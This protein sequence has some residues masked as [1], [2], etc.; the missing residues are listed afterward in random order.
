[1]NEETLSG[2]PNP[3]PEISLEQFEQQLEV[4]EKGRALA[5]FVNDVNW[6][7]VLQVLQDYRD[8]A[9]DALIALPPGDPQVPLAHAAASATH[10]VFRNFQ[11]DISRAVDFA[12]NPPAEFKQ[13]MLGVRDS[14]DVA[15]I[16][17]SRS[18]ER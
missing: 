9:R 7:T 1:M 15:K 3:D 17:E 10:E 2:L 18:V 4:F 14:L 13:R 12:Q 5:R 8:N 11:E 6:E 16:M